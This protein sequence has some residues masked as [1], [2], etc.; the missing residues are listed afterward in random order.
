MVTKPGRRAARAGLGTLALALALTACATT[1]PAPATSS[2]PSPSP[3]EIR[4]V[5]VTPR[6]IAALMLEHLPV[7]TPRPGPPGSTTTL[8]RV[9]WAPNCAIT[10]ARATTATW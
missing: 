8:P 6:A 7:T 9:S 3:S 2:S 10:P 1:T 5:P 4:S